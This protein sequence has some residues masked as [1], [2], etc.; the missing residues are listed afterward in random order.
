LKTAPL[1]LPPV[2]DNSVDLSAAELG[3][4]P[5]ISTSGSITLGA[6][7]KRGCI[8]YF[9]SRTGSQDPT[10][11]QACSIGGS[12][13]TLLGF[14]AINTEQGFWIYG[15]TGLPSGAC[16]IAASVGNGFNTGR[17]LE[18]AVLSYTGCSTL[19]GVM[20]TVTTSTTQSQTVSSNALEMVAQGFGGAQSGIF[21]SYT[22]GTQRKNLQ[23]SS[24]FTELVVG[25]APG[26]ASV[27]QSCTS[28]AN[29]PWA[30][31]AVRIAA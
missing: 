19:T 23:S 20:G 30:P 6:A 5:S 31:G 24:G 17:S 10:G 13:A 8:V 26:A 11:Q 7:P 3:F 18:V 15:S 14:L 9:S 4:N 1:L 16:A 12:A 29:A 2:F 21:A 28:P 22:G 25:D 27:T